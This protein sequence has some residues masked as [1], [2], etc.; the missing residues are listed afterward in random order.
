MSIIKKKIGVLRFELLMTMLKL[1]FP[2]FYFI[3][4]ACNYAKI[5][6]QKKV[7]KTPRPFTLFL[8]KYYQEKKISGVEIGVNTGKNAKSLF[9]EL[10]IK[11]LYLIDCWENYID[12]YY[13]IEQTNENY[14]RV[15]KIFENKCQVKIIKKYSN[16][17]ISL[18][19]DNSLDFVYIDGNH[20]Y[21]YVFDDLE[22][23]YPKL[24]DKG[25]IGG[26]D[27]FY[28]W[29]VYNAVK[30]WCKMRDLYFY[31]RFPDFIIIK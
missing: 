21:N 3:L 27:I 29:D 6:E 4:K 5:R 7:A 25:I 2:K 28:V 22:L 13:H 11:D 19:D 20:K 12:E 15:L 24:K 10:N 30:D 31:I 26:H 23:W 16:E 8:K 1:V 18:F 9:R 17:A 14:L